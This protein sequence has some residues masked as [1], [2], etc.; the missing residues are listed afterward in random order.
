MPGLAKNS[1]L[2]ARKFADAKYVTVLTPDEVLIF[3]DLGDLKL[4]ITQEEILKGWRCKTTGLWRVTLACVML[5]EKEDTILL[6]RPNP[7][8]EIKSAYE[9]PS[10]EQLIR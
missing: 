9:F 3:K 7:K 10:T 1:L 2:S 5:D 4:T 6:Y 8:H